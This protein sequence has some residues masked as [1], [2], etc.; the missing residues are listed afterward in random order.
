MKKSFARYLSS[1]VFKTEIS[2]K[3]V[4]IISGS[5]AVMD[6]MSTALLDPAMNGNKSDAFICTP[7]R[8]LLSRHHAVLQLV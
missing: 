1:H 2:E 4:L 8:C 5:G 3:D 7:F 6:V